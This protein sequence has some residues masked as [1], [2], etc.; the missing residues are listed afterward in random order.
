MIINSYPDKVVINA[1][2][3]VKPYY[4][5]NTEFLRYALYQIK[6]ILGNRP[7]HIDAL[8]N[9]PLNTAPYCGIVDLIVEELGL[10]ASRILLHIRDQEFS[11]PGV[12]VVPHNHWDERWRSQDLNEYLIGLENLPDAPDIK[13]FGCLFGRMQLGR[14]LL[15]HHLDFHHR[16]KSFVVFQCDKSLFDPQIHGIEEYF[17]IPII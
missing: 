10:P 6:Y 13:R 8:R 17:S 4:M 1:C 9:T 12:T 3:P 16:D 14:L 11:H 5:A 15:A 2:I 7:V